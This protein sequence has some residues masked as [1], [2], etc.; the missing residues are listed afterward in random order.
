MIRI[1]KPLAVREYYFRSVRVEFLNS[2][3]LPVEKT[4]MSHYDK[5]D[6]RKST[7]AY[8][9]SGRWLFYYYWDNF[10]II[11]GLMEFS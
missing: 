9:I 3:F 10:Y 2:N 6:S 5:I 4:K 11:L 7:M 8:S 1:P